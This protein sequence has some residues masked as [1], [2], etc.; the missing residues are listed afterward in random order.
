MST[1]RQVNVG[2]I[3]IYPPKRG[4]FKVVSIEDKPGYSEATLVLA[5]RGCGK[6]APV[7]K[8][9]ENTGE[10]VYSKVGSFVVRV[11]ELVVVTHSMVEVWYETE[12]NAA[13][14]KKNNLFTLLG[15]KPTNKVRPA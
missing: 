12:R 5:V 7:E 1:K 2:S 15:P 8:I 9:D 4:Y 3:V 10:A 13:R 11:D 6:M 14:K